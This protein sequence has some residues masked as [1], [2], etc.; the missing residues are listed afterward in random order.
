MNDTVFLQIAGRE[1]VVTLVVTAAGIYFVFLT[2]TVLV[3]SVCPVVGLIP[4]GVAVV[5]SDFFT[6]IVRVVYQT[7][8]PIAIAQCGI[9]VQLSVHTDE[10]LSVG[11]SIYL[12]AQ[13]TDQVAIGCIVSL[14]SRHTLRVEV[15]VVESS[16][17]QLIVFG[18]VVNLVILLY[19]TAVGT[20]AH[21]YVDARCRLV[22]L[23]G[24]DDDDTGSTT[25]TV[26]SGRSGIL[27][28]R[29]RL[30]VLLRDVAQRRLIGSTID[31]DQR[32]GL[33]I[34]RSNTADVDLTLVGT[35]ST[36]AATNLQARN[37]TGQCI[38]HVG[39]HVLVELGGTH[40]RGR[41]RE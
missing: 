35:R 26:Q 29:H 13:S 6:R 8:L 30:D 34:H 31:N 4:V 39:G 28:Y 14:S 37:R 22:T 1:E 24:G 10:L 12:I 32:V 25:G 23:L 16:V 38:G 7:R 27:Q 9:G 3:G 40:H 15:V 19:G 17:C 21:V 5:L 18:R 20:P 2:E 33:G 36:R 41:T 11:H